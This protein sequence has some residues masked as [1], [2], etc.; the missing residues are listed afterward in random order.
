MKNDKL[1][2]NHYNRIF[3]VRFLWITSQPTVIGELEEIVSYALETKNNGIE[4][5][6]EIEGSKIRKVS[7]NELKEMLS[8]K[9]ID[10]ME[11][12]FKVY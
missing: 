7:K 12:L 4:S 10:L 9:Y 6:Y 3:M 5:F 2:I 1:F 11:R 8:Y